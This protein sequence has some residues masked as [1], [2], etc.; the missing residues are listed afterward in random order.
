MVTKE[1]ANIR[2]LGGFLA[3]H[4]TLRVLVNTH[5][6]CLDRNLNEAQLMLDLVLM[7]SRSTTWKNN[8]EVVDHPYGDSDSYWYRRA[9]D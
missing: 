1:A 5:V 9:D 7:L 2:A 6:L 3:A 4:R 8:S